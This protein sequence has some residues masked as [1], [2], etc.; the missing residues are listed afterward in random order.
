M[1]SVKNALPKNKGEKKGLIIQG[2]I[3][4]Q[5]YNKNY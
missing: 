3:R 2:Y 5:L 4:E 1:K